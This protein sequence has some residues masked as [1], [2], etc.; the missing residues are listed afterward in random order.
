MEKRRE[1][2]RQEEM[3]KKKHSAWRIPLP[4][5]ECRLEEGKRSLIT[6]PFPRGNHEVLP[7][8]CPF[9][10][11]TAHVV[12]AARPNTIFAFANDGPKLHLS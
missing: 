2:G 12:V 3:G 8:K 7:L 11:G 10:R 6:S 9:P 5:G 4:V 1:G